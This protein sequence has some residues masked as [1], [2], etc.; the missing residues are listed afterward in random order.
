ML[1]PPPGAMSPPPPFTPAPG[2]AGSSNNNG[3][4]YAPWAVPADA[5]GAPGNVG[6]AG[7]SD[8]M[9][10]TVPMTA[11]SDSKATFRGAGGSN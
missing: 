11:P 2:G 8:G 3:L 10:R 7:G 6:G 1:S 4:G 9:G 5:G